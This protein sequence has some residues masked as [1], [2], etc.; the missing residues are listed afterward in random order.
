MPSKGLVYGNGTPE[1]MLNEGF[2][3]DFYEKHFQDC[4]NCE[5][6]GGMCGSSVTPPLQFLCFC[7]DRHQ[8]AL[9]L[10]LSQVITY[11]SPALGFLLFCD[12][13]VHERKVRLLG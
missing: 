11:A 2:E 7:K 8:P 5:D 4:L 6:S 3:M 10:V 13:M 12:Q 1:N 9:L